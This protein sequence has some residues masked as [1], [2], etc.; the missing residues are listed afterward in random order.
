MK[1][2]S[3]GLP[4]WVNT[5]LL[6][7]VILLLP[8]LE[9]HLSLL[10]FVAFVPLLGWQEI[11]VRRTAKIGLSVLASFLAIFLWQSL[12]LVWLA[13]MGWGKLLLITFCNSLIFSLPFLLRALFLKWKRPVLSN[14]IWLCSWIGLE[15]LHTQW[16]LAFPLF[17]LGN[18][19]A[20]WPALIQWYEVTGVFGGSLWV[21]AGNLVLLKTWGYG[22]KALR[23]RL[24]PVAAV[25]VLPV[26]ASLAFQVS[27]Q[28][29]PRN[30]EVISLHPNT[31]CY[32]EKFVL[33]QR[34]LVESY[35]AETERALTHKTQF[36]LWPETAIARGQWMDN[37]NNDPE[38][39]LIQELLS[40]YPQLNFIAGINTFQ[41]TTSPSVRGTSMQTSY[42]V[43]AEPSYLS[44]NAVLQMADQQPNQLR[45]KSRLVPFEET[46]KLPAI[47]GPFQRWIDSASGRAYSILKR[48]PSTQ[49]SSD[50]RTRS[51]TL[52]CYESAF[53]SVSAD[54]SRKG[55]A[56]LFV[57]LNEGWYDH[58]RGAWKF[59]DLSVIR[60]IETRK[61]VVRSSNRGIS[62]AISPTGV[63]LESLSISKASTLKVSV[64]LN[65][66]RTMYTRF[67]DWVAYLCLFLGILCFPA[68]L[69]KAERSTFKS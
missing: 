33:P 12:D 41:P 27:F 9:R 50:R 66:K 6:S 25:L 38:I 61:S 47:L 48:N 64:S 22:I 26:L 51:G 69:I 29:G 67:G 14:L 39:I 31:D 54:M 46:R 45:S 5:A 56:I 55:A 23:R 21:L 18:F 63:V 36:V 16:S 40:R 8:S 68:A 37:L 1:S 10:L 34:Q 49:L 15:F 32:S 13:K 42:L 28:E 59:L 4:A 52:I 24:I 43:E 44:Y 60:A 17:Q 11:F 20:A 19:F 62:A 35:L 7:A 2:I 3:T 30:V 65:D 57:L 58:L 53:G